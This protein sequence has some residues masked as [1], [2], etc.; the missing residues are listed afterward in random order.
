MS[1]S[2]AIFSSQM[3]RIAETFGRDNF[4]KPRLEEIYKVVKDL[5]DQDFIKI[6]SRIVG[7]VP[8]KYPPTVIQFREFAETKLKELRE[9]GGPQ[10]W[11]TAMDEI[12]ERK[13]MLEALTPEQREERKKR[14]RE[15][16]SK[17]TKVMP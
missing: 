13:K 17:I 8:I 15:M 12:A 4:P 1:L 5:P 3:N 6:I 14:I 7:E 10:G 2:K 16:A 11:E 9:R